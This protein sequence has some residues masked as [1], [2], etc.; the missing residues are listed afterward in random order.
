LFEGDRKSSRF[1]SLECYYKYTRINSSSST[2]NYL[3]TCDDNYPLQHRKIAEDFIGRKLLYNE[4]VHHLDGNSKN[5]NISNLIVMQRGDHVRL[6]ATLT[7]HRASLLKNKDENSENCWNNL[8][9]QITTTWLE[10]EGVKV[11]KI[12]DIGQSA[13]ETPTDISEE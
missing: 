1:Y 7:R 5:N 13:A 12:S 11:I 8:R 3:H 10:T 9:G 6:H 4:V 2:N